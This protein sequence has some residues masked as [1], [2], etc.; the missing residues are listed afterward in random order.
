M[1]IRFPAPTGWSAI[2]SFGSAIATRRMILP[3]VL[4][5][6][7]LGSSAHALCSYRGELYART[8]V[9][10]EL[11]DSRWVVRAKVLSA[12]EHFVEGEEP[13]TEYQL[14]VLHAYK[15][16]P[17]ARLRFFTLRNSGGFYLDRGREHDVGGEYLLFLNPTSNS[18]EIPAAA[19]GTVS[20]NYSCGVSGPWN[21]VTT[22]SRADLVRL[23]R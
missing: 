11:R 9:S 4:A 6:S 18:P 10:Q 20:V 23:S 21:H 15:G 16:S 8:T 19:S 1:D 2:E 13:W 14:E 3:L 5:L 7:A 12:T 22:E 17:A